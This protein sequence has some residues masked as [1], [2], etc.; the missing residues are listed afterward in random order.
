MYIL[1]Q[2]TQ[3][4]LVFDQAGLFRGSEVLYSTCIDTEVKLLEGSF[5]LQC[6]KIL[7]VTY[8]HGKTNNIHTT[9]TNGI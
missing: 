6:I 3:K 2:S 1:V 9:C 8:I 7:Q 4:Q 5:V